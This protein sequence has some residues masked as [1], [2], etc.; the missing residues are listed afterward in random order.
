MAVQLIGLAIYSRHNARIRL[1]EGA[2]NVD[3]SGVGKANILL[4]SGW[5]V[6]MLAEVHLLARPFDFQIGLVSAVLAS[7]ALGLRILSM[8]QLGRRWTLPTIVKPGEKREGRGIYSLLRHPNWVGVMIEI[9]AI[10]MIHGAWMTA[11]LFGFLETVLLV[12]RWETEEAALAGAQFP[13][14]K[15]VGAERIP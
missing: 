13:P 3:S 9:V 10:P 1:A 5:I 7:A 15:M 8:I 6:A 2:I 12:G 4:R 11:L 14:S